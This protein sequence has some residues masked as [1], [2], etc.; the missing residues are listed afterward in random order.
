MKNIR[1]TSG[2]IELD[3]QD[4]SKE[5]FLSLQEK[6]DIP[7]DAIYNGWRIDE[8]GLTLTLHYNYEKQEQT[9]N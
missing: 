2:Q 6:L 4:L 5:V 9:S 8:S 1:P 3:M 7:K